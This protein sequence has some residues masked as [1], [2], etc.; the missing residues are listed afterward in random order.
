M[1]EPVT[2]NVRM[3]RLNELGDCFLLT[4]SSGASKTRLLMDCGSFRNGAPSI[5]RLKAIVR[6]INVAQQLVYF[7]RLWVGGEGGIR[8]HVPVTR[9]DAFEAPPL[10]PL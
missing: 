8:T 6:A 9:Q 4:F 7:Q 10:R 5:A 1:S 2:V 3:Y